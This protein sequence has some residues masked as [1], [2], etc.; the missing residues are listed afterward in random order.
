MAHTPLFRHLTRA[1]RQAHAAE[2]TGL[3]VDA[4]L[5][6]PLSR[7]RVLQGAGAL[8]ALS[9]LPACTRASQHPASDDPVLIVGAGLAGLTAAWRLRQAGVPVRVVDAQAR[10]GGRMHSLR[11]HFAPGQVAE[12]GG[13]LIDTDHTT[14]QRLAREVGLTL[15]DYQEDDPRLAK[16]RW[17]FGGR[18]RS[19]AELV[20]AFRPVAREVLRAREELGTEGFD[21]RSPG[22]ATRLDRLPLAQWLEACEAEGWVRQLL[23]VAYATEYGRATSEQSALNLLVMLSPESPPFHLY[24]DSDERFHLRGGNDALPRALAERVQDAL[25]LETRLEA[26]REGSAGGYT[27][28]FRRGGRSHTL[29]ARTLVLAL[30]FSLLRDVALEVELP[31]VKRQAIAHLRYGTN[32]KLMVGFSARPW[33][34]QHGSNGSTLT[35]LEYQVTWETSRLQPGAAGIL[36][37]FT[38]AAAGLALGE[39]TAAA[40]AQR[41]TAELERVFPGT[42]ALRTTEARFHWPSHP[43]TRGSYSCYGPGDWTGFGGAEGE[44]VGGLH[45]AGEHCSRIAQGFMEGAAETGEAVARAILQERQLRAPG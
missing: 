24:G 31:A 21:Y 30:P 37:N 29:S 43:F 5:E 6:R 12:L 38:G 18:L 27:C 40:Q 2:R 34:A 13:E 44:R 23:D 42:A 3:P 17:Y 19:E 22:R 9:A 14:V 8:A 16:D 41:F 35:D 25:V 4:L 33:R 36:T 39:G 7:R 26:V 1:L 32:A 20:E 28:S 11:G 45:F 10:V 15:E